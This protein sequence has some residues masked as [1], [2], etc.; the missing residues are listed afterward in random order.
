MIWGLG[1]LSELSADLSPA[2]A[3]GKIPGV[4][5]FAFGGEL[6]PF[7]DELYSK[8]FTVT[9]QPQ[10]AMPDSGFV[11]L[12]N[13]SQVLSANNKSSVASNVG[14]L[15]SSG[16]YV[17]GTAPVTASAVVAKVSD[18]KTGKPAGPLT[19]ES[20]IDLVFSTAK[21]LISVTQAQKAAD[22]L[23]KKQARGE[24]VYKSSTISAV[25]VA[26]VVG[27]MLALGVIGYSVFGK[28][29]R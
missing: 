18:P 19:P 5:S 26:L 20:A 2:E 22:A 27:G 29:R 10:G 7:I 17:K 12:V 11:D 1:A 4:V 15:Q 25:N 24:P 9:D 23:L 13:S 28:G 3:K 6:E 8:G 14:R 16:F 21:G